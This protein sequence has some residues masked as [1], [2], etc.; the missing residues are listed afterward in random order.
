MRAVS[1]VA[2]RSVWGAQ[3]SH[4]TSDPGDPA[5]ALLGRHARLDFRAMFGRKS[6]SIQSISELYIHSFVEQSEVTEAY[7]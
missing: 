2:R 5:S 6:L 7:T 1:H 4:E 3:E